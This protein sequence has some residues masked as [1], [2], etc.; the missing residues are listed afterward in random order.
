MNTATLKTMKTMA[1]KG[2]LNSEIASA[3]DIPRSAVAAWRQ[4]DFDPALRLYT[5]EDHDAEI[6]R[7]RAKGLSCRE[8]SERIGSV[9]C[10]SAVRY[11]LRRTAAKVEGGVL[12]W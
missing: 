1:A 9:L 4:L 12:R 8:I 11:R 2:A 5:G 7:L 6:E 10:E 3:L